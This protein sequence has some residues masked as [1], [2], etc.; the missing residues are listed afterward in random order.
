MEPRQRPTC[1][2]ACCGGVLPGRWTRPEPT[3][4]PGRYDYVANADQ[5]CSYFQYRRAEL[6]DKLLGEVG[7]PPE[8]GDIGRCRRECLRRTCARGGCQ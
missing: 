5:G 4:D 2:T 3:T 6:L 7:L 8:S 1:K